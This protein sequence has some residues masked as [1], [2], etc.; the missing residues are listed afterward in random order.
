MGLP[1]RPYMR[2]LYPQDHIFDILGGRGTEAME[3]SRRTGVVLE[4]LNQ[5]YITLIPK[6]DKPSSFNDYWLVA[7]C[8]LLYKL[9]S[10]IIADWL[11]PSLSKAIFAEKFGF[12]PGWK[13]LDDVGIV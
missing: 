7:L 3:Y 12:L 13:I 11:K 6:S 2:H 4:A 5:T 1:S 9:I 8:N 10:R